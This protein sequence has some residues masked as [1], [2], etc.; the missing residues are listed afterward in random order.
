MSAPIPVAP[1]VAAITRHRPTV[2][3]DRKDA[4]TLTTATQDR[5]GSR[6]SSV[7]H[8]AGTAVPAESLPGLAIRRGAGTAGYTGGPA[9]PMYSAPCPEHEAEVPPWGTPVDEAIFRDCV[10]CL[11]S[12][13]HLHIQCLRCRQMPGCCQCLPGL[14]QTTD[15][16]LK[17][18]TS[19]FTGLIGDNNYNN[20]N[21]NIPASPLPAFMI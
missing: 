16:P 20:N 7:D 12:G 19:R 6:P 8:F 13:R 1:R 2:Y 21:N 10:V 18:P 3:G 5:L 11:D 14:T 15:G 4:T 17:C 9:P